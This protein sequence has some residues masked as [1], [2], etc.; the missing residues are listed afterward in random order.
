MEQQAAI[1]FIA[2]AI[3]AR[4][5]VWA[6]LG[7][8]SGTFTRALA[9]LIG[10][11]GTV[12]AVDRDAGSLRDLA[13]VRGGGKTRATIK[14]IVGDFTEPLE[15]PALDGVL[16]A[17]ALHYVAYDDQATVMRRIAALAGPRAPIVIVEYD[18]RS[19]NRYVPYPITPTTLATVAAE[20]GLTPPTILATRPS[21]YSGTMYSAVVRLR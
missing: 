19:A 6:D 18:R 7:A 16:L 14:T 8:G 3:T 1:E 21:Q 11:D 10:P 4:G 17:N 2:A 15:L 20:A 5:G 13:Q 12:Y 9:S